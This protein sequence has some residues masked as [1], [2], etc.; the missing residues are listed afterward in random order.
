MGTRSSIPVWKIPWKEEPGVLESMGSQRVRHD[1][2]TKQQ[3]QTSQLV[4]ILLLSLEYSLH[5][6]GHQSFIKCRIKTH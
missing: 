2:V 5:V 1:L 3:Q 6:S 4:T